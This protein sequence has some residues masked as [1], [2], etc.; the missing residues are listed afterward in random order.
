MRA[1][2]LRIV[3]LITLSAVAG[4]SDSN[5]VTGPSAASGPS[6]STLL[7][8]SPTTV[9]VVTRDTPLAAAQTASASVGIWGGYIA[10]PG[11]GLSVYIPPFALS[12][13]TLITVTAVAGNQV[14]YEFGPHGTQFR[15]PVLVSQQLQGT[16]AWNGG[17][18]PSRLLAGYFQNVTDLDQLN[19]TATVSE[20]LSTSISAVTG[21]VTF[22]I[23]HFSGYLIATGETGEVEGSGVQ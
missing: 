6:P 3:S 21:R 14:A 11:A 15:V 7:L 16:S 5:T 10:L 18:L 4:C 20:L 12:S 17:V 23:T 13:T 2:A 22:G 19:A 9:N 1:T 8:T